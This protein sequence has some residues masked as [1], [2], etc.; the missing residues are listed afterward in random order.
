MFY[1][2]TTVLSWTKLFTQETLGKIAKITEKATLVQL[3]NE[4]AEKQSEKVKPIP[5]KGTATDKVG[6]KSIGECELSRRLGWQPGLNGDMFTVDYSVF[7]NPPLINEEL[8]Y[9]PEIM[10]AAKSLSIRII[11]RIQKVGVVYNNVHYSYMGVTASSVKKGVGIFLRD[12]V[13]GEGEGKV[14]PLFTEEELSKADES[15]GGIS[16]SMWARINTLQI[17]LILTG[18]KRFSEVAG[19]NLTLD[20][21]RFIEDLEETP[22]VV[23][24]AKVI[25]EKDGKVIAVN[26]NSVTMNV[27]AFDGGSVYNRDIVDLKGAYQ[28]RPFKSLMTPV[29][30]KGAEALIG[31][32]FEL[33]TD[34]DGEKFDIHQTKVLVNTSNCKM[35]EVARILAP[36]KPWAFMKSCLKRQ[37]WNALAVVHAFE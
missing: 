16:P 11:E 15:C 3:F 7:I 10:E 13:I 20:D 26:K 19:A 27:L 4:L 36:E 35:I 8:K 28:V 31:K 22:I 9:D 24:S 23:D 12:E 25:T 29:S 37:G 32:E 1:V 6:D 18:S 14:M 30:F 2:L 34:V 5:V 21:V 33:L 17:S